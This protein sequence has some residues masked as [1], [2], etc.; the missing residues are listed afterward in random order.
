[1][2]AVLAQLGER[3]TVNV[4]PTAAFPSPSFAII[5]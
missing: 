5:L 3:A 4:H 1:M 2:V